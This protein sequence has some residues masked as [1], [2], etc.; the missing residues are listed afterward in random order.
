M[1]LCK[2]K[3][4]RPIL[5]M[6]RSRILSYRNPLVRNFNNVQAQKLDTEKEVAH[7]GNLADTWWN[8]DGPMRALHAMNT[9]RVPFIRDGLLARGDISSELINTANVLKNQKILDVGCGGGILS[10]QL[11]RLGAFVTGIDLGEELIKE[12][13]NHLH[14]HSTELSKRIEYKVE[15][16]A[17]HA[18]THSD[19]YDAVILSEVLEHV[20]DKAAM[21]TS[22]VHA[23]KPGGSLFITTINKT[24]P[25]WIGSILLGEYVLKIAP[26]GTHHWDKMASP[27]EVQRILDALNCYTVVINGST[28]DFWSNTW[29]WINSTNLCFAIQAVKENC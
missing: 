7:H 21:L 10:E 1:I 11:A 23:L 13:K 14:K 4:F 22:S 15:D 16:I 26:K 5:L 27:I 20:S 12:A 18:Q 6:E 29:R 19:N 24:V 8:V 9:I 3:T 2:I 28:Y 25:M 17:V